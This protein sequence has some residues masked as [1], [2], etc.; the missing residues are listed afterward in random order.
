MSQKPKQPQDAEAI[1]FPTRQSLSAI[2]LTMWNGLTL[3][4]T[5]VSLLT[6]CLVCQHVFL[7]SMAELR[8]SRLSSDS[9]AR[10]EVMCL[11]L[12]IPSLSRLFSFANKQHSGSGLLFARLVREQKLEKRCRCHSRTKTFF[13][14]SLVMP[15]Q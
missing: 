7:N 13:L 9:A 15:K 5:R 3:R 14:A 10:R 12:S 2:W 1:C 11:L 8:R 4:F 6:F